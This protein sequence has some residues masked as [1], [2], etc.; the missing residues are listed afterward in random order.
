MFCFFLGGCHFEFSSEKNWGIENDDCKIF[1]SIDITHLADSIASVPFNL[2]HNIPIELFTVEQLE[3]FE[4][5]A[6]LALSRHT[7][8][9]NSKLKNKTEVRTSIKCSQK[10]ETDKLM[11]LILNNFSSSEES[12]ITSDGQLD[13]IL[14]NMK[15]LINILQDETNEVN[16]IG[17]YTLT[18]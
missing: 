14:G 13:A 6:S 12:N 2:R 15:P 9:C 10:P 1:D 11:K 8:Q 4:V 17:I 18:Q 3:E 5:E 16:S 7:F